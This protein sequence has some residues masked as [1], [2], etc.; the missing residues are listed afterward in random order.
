MAKQRIQKLLAAAGFGSRRA[1]E[2]MVLEGRVCVNGERLSTLPALADPET[3]T[4]TIDGRAIKV[5]GH[6]YFMLNK[7]SGVYCTHNDPDDRTRAVDLLVG[8][9]ERVYPVGRL[10]AETMGLLLLTND[11][12]L[13]QQLTHPRFGVQKT[14]RVE[15]A[16]MTSENVLNKLRSGV[17]L[18]EGRT[19]PASIEVIHANRNRS[20]LEITLRESRNREIRRALAKLG[21]NVRRIVRVRMGR[22]TI[23][24]LPVGA[25]RPLTADEVKYLRSIAAKTPS[26]PDK[27]WRPA[28]RK[29]S[30]P[31]RGAPKGRPVARATTPRSSSPS[32]RII[33]PDSKARG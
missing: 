5:Q 6:V 7:P 13:A 24:K 9:R 27:N 2:D 1:C 25:F 18:S 8:V 10:E 17:W 29:G 19:A 31:R 23:S 33:L 4:I 16:G 28:P 12:E 3:D 26:V 11:G 21:H 32:R 22:L 30:G 20:I 15:V 14:Y